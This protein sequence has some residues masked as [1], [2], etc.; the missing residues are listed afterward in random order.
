MCIRDRYHIQKLYKFT[1]IY[2]YCIYTHAATVIVARFI[3]T[4]NLLAGILVKD[5]KM[6]RYMYELSILLAQTKLYTVF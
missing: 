2:R 3:T 1:N 5:Y 6:L 4:N